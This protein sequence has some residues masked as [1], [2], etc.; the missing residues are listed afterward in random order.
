M[1]NPKMFATLDL[2][3]SERPSHPPQRPVTAGQRCGS[4]V[5]MGI[6][7]HAS[8]GNIQPPITVLPSNVSTNHGGLPRVTSEII[9]GG[10]ARGVPSQRP[11]TASALQPSIRNQSTSSSSSNT[12]PVIEIVDDTL[13]SS[14]PFAKKRIA[15]HRA[16]LAQ[17]MSRFEDK[18]NSNADER[19]EI[20][21]T[22]R[23]NESS[24][25]RSIRKTWYIYIFIYIY[26]YI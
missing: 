20:D 11:K 10:I 14:I 19:K 15:A 24:D 1:T 3:K 23:N 7:R 4:E 26:I 13:G 16:M 9:L 21:F 6:Q 2:N 25:E 18:D 17:S 12:P 8:T 5:K 22:Y